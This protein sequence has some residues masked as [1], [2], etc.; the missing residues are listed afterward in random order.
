[1]GR[2]VGEALRD[3]VA[4]RSGEAH[5]VALA[6]Q[7][8]VE[9]LVR[10]APDLRFEAPLGGLTLGERLRWYELNGSGARSDLWRAARRR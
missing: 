10:A 5:F 6:S 2:M 7:R 9:L 3:R 4:Q 1:M 8:T